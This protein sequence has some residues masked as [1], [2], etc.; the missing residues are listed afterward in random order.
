VTST[1][2]TPKTLK[3]PTTRVAHLRRGRP[4]RDEAGER[5]I[6]RA[7]ELMRAA[8]M[9]FA[10]RG[11]RATT[12]DSLSE[13][14]GIP[15]AVLYRYFPSKDEL[16]HA[17]LGRILDQWTELHNRPWRGLSNNLRDVIAL[18]RANPDE[19]RLLVRNCETDPELRRYYDTL[20]STIVR[21]TEELLAEASEGMASDPVIR[22][23]SSHAVAGFMLHGVLWWIE[24]ADPS[25]DEDFMRWARDSLGTLYRRWMPDAD[26]RPRQP[27]GNAK[28]ADE[29]ERP[30]MRKAEKTPSG[31]PG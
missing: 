8:A 11:P 24:H 27:H 5:R 2:R 15:K 25:R 12:M 9:V 1:T 3:T 19:L 31:K 20:H 16:L 13:A 14:L 29:A 22:T 6:R 17:I 26:W 28:S 23:L 10:E 21:F 18:A 30:A 7:G 4:R